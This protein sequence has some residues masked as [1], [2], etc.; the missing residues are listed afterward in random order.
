MYMLSVRLSETGI[1]RL[2]NAHQLKLR[3]VCMRPHS[4]FSL[5]SRTKNKET[6]NREIVTVL[7]FRLS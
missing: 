5:R 4:L 6:G 2:N 3:F 7:V 1:G